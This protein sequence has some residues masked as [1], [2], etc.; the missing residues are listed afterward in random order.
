MA[1]SPLDMAHVS[2]SPCLCVFVTD[3]LQGSAQGG[4]GWVLPGKGDSGEGGGE[5]SG[6]EPHSHCEVEFPPTLLQEKEKEPWHLF[7]HSFLS[8]SQ[9]LC[10]WIAAEQS[11]GGH[12]ATNHR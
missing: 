5:S 2:M 1:R 11:R 9:L 6:K 4:R 10:T 3:A 12:G 7:M 8:S